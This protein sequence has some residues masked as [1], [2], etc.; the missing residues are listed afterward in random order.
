MELGIEFGIMGLTI[1]FSIATMAFWIWMLVDCL[2]KVR[3][4]GNDKLIWALVI[5]FANGLGALI[6]FFVQRPKNIK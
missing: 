4:D 1:L 2:T 5:I 3:S 6:Y